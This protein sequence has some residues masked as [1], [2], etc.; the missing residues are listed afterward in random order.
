ME[1]AFSLHS[2]YV[3]YTK[4]RLISYENDR[5]THSNNHKQFL[6]RTFQIFLSKPT[7]IENV[8]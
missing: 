5:M 4:L 8:A 2:M 3:T 7:C 6:G 1:E